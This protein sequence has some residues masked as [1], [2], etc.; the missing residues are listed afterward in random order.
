MKKTILIYAFA[1]LAIV[2]Y[3]K[4][5]TYLL[6]GAIVDAET[7]LPISNATVA[8][9][10]DSTFTST[11]GT[12][13]LKLKKKQYYLLVTH[14]SYSPYA[15]LRGFI[16]SNEKKVDTIK[17]EKLR[18]ILQTLEVTSLRAN[19]KSPFAKTNLN[20]SDIAQ[21]NQGYDIPVLLNQ[22]PSLLVNSDAGNGIGYTYMRIRGTDA[23]RINVTLN[24][25][26]YNDA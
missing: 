24:G 23:S 5:K 13:S 12:F 18:K 4:K 22:T 14:I 3:K 26:P 16:D 8:C 11:E 15:I 19:D 7:N 1:L 25:I 21:L 17:L 10:D 9:Y 6:K 20:K 2:N